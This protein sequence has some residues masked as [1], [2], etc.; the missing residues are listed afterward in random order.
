VGGQTRVD[1]RTSLA[2]GD[3]WQSKHANKVR[4]EPVVCARRNIG[5]GLDDTLK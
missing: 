4:R 5:R 1:G 2:R 3:E